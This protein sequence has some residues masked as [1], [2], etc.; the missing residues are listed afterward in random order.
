MTSKAIEIQMRRN[1]LNLIEV[2]RVRLQKEISELERTA[3]SNEIYGQREIPAHYDRIVNIL[4]PRLGTLRN[5]Y[6][7]NDPIQKN[8]TVYGFEFNNIGDQRIVSTH[9]TQQLNEMG[10]YVCEVNN[11]FIYIGK[12]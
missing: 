9:E 4:T 7:C 3:D 12:S 11:H 1:A 2:D 8:Y 6:R 10:Y 5:I